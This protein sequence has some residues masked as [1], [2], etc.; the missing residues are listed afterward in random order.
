[1]C[2]L[3]FESAEFWCNE[4]VWEWGEEGSR[5]DSNSVTNLT[6]LHLHQKVDNEGQNNFTAD[7]IN[8]TEGS[9]GHKWEFYQRQHAIFKLGTMC[10]IRLIGYSVGNTGY[11]LSNKAAQRLKSAT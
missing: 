7:E 4:G 2:D 9:S 8:Q 11:H 6:F 5:L 10:S 3:K 1:M